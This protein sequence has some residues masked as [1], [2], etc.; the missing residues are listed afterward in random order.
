MKKINPFILI[1]I[2]IF[3]VIVLS[4]FAPV[5]SQTANAIICRFEA[6]ACVESWGSNIVVYPGQPNATMTPS[7]RIVATS[8]AVYGKVLAASTPG[9]TCNRGTNTITDTVTYTSTVTSIAT[10]T[11]GS[12]SLQ[13][14]SGDAARAAINVATPGS[15]IITVRNSNAT[16]AANAAGAVVHWEVCGTGQ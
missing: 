16:P 10:L 4:A 1:T 6:T 7:F 11:W 8:G 15:A 12:A 3:A 5:L 13:S 14:I 2:G 9:I